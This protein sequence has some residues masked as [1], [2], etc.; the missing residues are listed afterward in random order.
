[1][2][3]LHSR[4]AEGVVF[5]VCAIVMGEAGFSTDG[6]RT[7]HSNEVWQ[8]L[9]K[10]DPKRFSPVT[11]EFTQSTNQI[12]RSNPAD[13][14]ILRD[15]RLTFLFGLFFGHV[16]VSKCALHYSCNQRRGVHAPR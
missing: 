9:A 15:A 2:A 5:Q 3:E 13:G 11:L 8:I 12:L 6:L 14:L 16:G 7:F 10:H 1:M 4:S